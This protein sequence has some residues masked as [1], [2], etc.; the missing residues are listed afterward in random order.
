VWISCSENSPG[1]P[2]YLIRFTVVD[3]AVRIPTSKN[4][5]S[6]LKLSPGSEAD[7]HEEQCSTGPE[8]EIVDLNIH[9]GKGPAEDSYTESKLRSEGGTFP[10]TS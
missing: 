1:G 8:R 9:D 7:F 6:V 3:M 5:V 2:K 4:F 10:M